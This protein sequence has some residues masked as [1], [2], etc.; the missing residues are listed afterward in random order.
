M[1]TP[2]PQPKP[3]L[4]PTAALTRRLVAFSLAMH[5]RSALA[6]KL[7]RRLA[8]NKPLRLQAV[9]QT[10]RAKPWSALLAEIDMLQAAFLRRLIAD[11]APAPDSS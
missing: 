11:A 2:A 7:A 1:A 9:R 5:D 3:E 10:A 6:R 4:R 8:K